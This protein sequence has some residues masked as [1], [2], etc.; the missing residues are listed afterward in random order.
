L[1]PAQTAEP[2]QRFTLLV[3]GQPQIVRTDQEFSL[4]VTGETKLKLTV[5]PNRSF[6]YGGLQF[7]YPS[8]FAFEAE[9]LSDSATWSL[10]GSTVVLMIF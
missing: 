2:P 3:N 4:N 5:D 1:L 9:I 6:E 7:D 10:D 8:S